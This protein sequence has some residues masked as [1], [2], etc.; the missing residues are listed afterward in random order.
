[1]LKGSLGRR[2]ASFALPAMKVLDEQFYS[3]CLVYN[4]PR[5]GLTDLVGGSLICI[6]CRE[7]HQTPFRTSTAMAREKRDHVVLKIRPETKL[8]HL[9]YPL[10]AGQT[11]W[12]TVP[13]RHQ[14]QHT[15]PL[16]IPKMLPD[17]DQ[18]PQVGSSYTF[19][20]QKHHPIMLSAKILMRKCVT[21]PFMRDVLHA[22]KHALA[23]KGPASRSLTPMEPTA[24]AKQIA[25][26]QKDMDIHGSF[27]FLRGKLKE[28]T[29]LLGGPDVLLAKRQTRHDIE[30]VCL[31]QHFFLHERDAFL[32]TYERLYMSCACM[33]MFA[34]IRSICMYMRV[35][36]SCVYACVFASARAGWYACMHA[37]VCMSALFWR[38]RVCT[39]VSAHMFVFSVFGVLLCDSDLYHDSHS[40]ICVVRTHT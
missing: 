18:L 13:S 2:N 4:T 19:A 33:I 30:E 11:R 32:C 7:R 22:K 39:I 21:L 31:L 26:L 35:C 20:A 16:R 1:M 17:G 25:A 12:T 3:D 34:R 10:S 5:Q 37:A 8:L 23:G 28:M 27:M 40:C 38:A 29:D 24:P 9:L 6:G 14:A 15:A 36:I